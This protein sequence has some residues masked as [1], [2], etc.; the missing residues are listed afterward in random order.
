VRIISGASKSMVSGKGSFE[1]GTALYEGTLRLT[2]RQAE[3]VR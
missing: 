1:G 3:I 2:G